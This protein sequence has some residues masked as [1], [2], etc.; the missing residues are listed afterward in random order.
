MSVILSRPGYASYPEMKVV[1]KVT[2][3]AYWHDCLLIL[4]SKAV[5]K[6][7]LESAVMQR[8]YIMNIYISKT[9]MAGHKK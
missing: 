3:W 4:D 9:S 2:R 7:G 8:V 6:A 5:S 1:M